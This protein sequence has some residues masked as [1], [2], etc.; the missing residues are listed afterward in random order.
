MSNILN[1]I[2]FYKPKRNVFKLSRERRMS[3]DFFRL[4]PSAV[5]ECYPDDVMKLR[6]EAFVRMSPMAAP[7]MH[8]FDVRTYWFFVPTRIIWDDFESFMS[9]KPTPE[10]IS[11]AAPKITFS[12][13]GFVQIAPKTLGNYMQLK[14]GLAPA[15]Q[16]TINSTF[17]SKAN[18]L[19][20]NGLTVSQLPFR[21]YQKIYNDWFL[22]GHVAQPND[23]VTDS[24]DLTATMLI[25]AAG[26]TD[27]EKKA[28][29]LTRIRM[30]AWQQ[31]YFTSCL[32]DPQRGPEVNA[33]DSVT[34]SVTLTGRGTVP[35]RN[36]FSVLASSSTK[37][38]SLSALIPA[39]YATYGF[40]SEA[41]AQAWVDLNQA[42]LT[43]AQDD[44]VRQNTG[45]TGITDSLVLNVNGI[46]RTFFVSRYSLGTDIAA[47][48][49]LTGNAGYGAVTVEE[50][51]IRLQMQQYLERENVVQGAGAGRYTQTLYAHWG[52]KGRDGRLQRAEF[53]GSAKQPIMINEVSQLSAPTD[54]DPLGQ[55][56]GQGVSASRGALFKFRCPEHG[57]IIALTCVTPRTAYMQG[58]P[59]MWTKFDRLDF[60][61][62]EFAHV[63]E[64]PVKYR[65]IVNNGFN[66]DD[67]FGY[68]LRNADLKVA[69][70][71][72]AGDF[73]GLLESWSAARSFATPV[74]AATVPK[75][76]A[77]FCRPSSSGEDDVDRIFPV[78]SSAFE[79]TNADHFVCD[80]YNHIRASRLMPRYSSPRVG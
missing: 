71:E 49:S 73:D 56:A 30:R 53:I 47:G 46:D 6:S 51:R 26:M 60:Y 41:S 1:S 65:E 20:P 69:Y 23:I 17:I 68:Q 59:R 64:E 35:I 29:A 28:Q 2:P 58:L 40:D 61:F 80:V 19:H 37:Y 77:A 22:P 79:T 78:E 75:L 63:G 21:A 24:N 10:Q 4:S 44:F 8:R 43:A 42:T 70:D 14:I 27:E 57:Y 36:Q 11:A 45:A 50:L 13:D 33:V 32:P 72:T 66:G 5:L 55:M 76:S 34:D 15:D 52:V 12:G 54:D 48:L 67:A 39:N 62:P 7:V 31:D 25:D 74:S 38:N 3:I 9:G 18:A 16:K